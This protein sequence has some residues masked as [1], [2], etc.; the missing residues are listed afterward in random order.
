[1]PIVLKSGNLNFLEPLGPVQAYTGIAFYSLVKKI[2]KNDTRSEPD[3]YN[4]MPVTCAALWGFND[5]T[6][7][8][9]KDLSETLQSNLQASVDLKYFN[10]GGGNGEYV[11]SVAVWEKKKKNYWVL[12]LPVHCS[13]VFLN[14]RAAARYRAL[15]SIIPGRERFLWNLSF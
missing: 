11:Y 13:P 4:T 14:G 9:I 10:R 12:I 15:V 5:S 2:T 1:M 8:N 7:R 6:S 3:T